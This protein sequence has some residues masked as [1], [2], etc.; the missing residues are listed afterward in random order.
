MHSF[1]EY[2]RPLRVA[3]LVAAAVVPWAPQSRA[4]TTPLACSTD[5]QIVQ[6]LTSNG[7][8]WEMC[9]DFTPYEGLVLRDIYFTAPGAERRKI[10]A[11]L[12]IGQI[13]VVYDKGSPRFEDVSDYGLAGADPSVSTLLSMSSSDCPGGSATISYM[14]KNRVCKRVDKNIEH[15]YRWYDT[16]TNTN[17]TKQ[18]SALVLYSMSKVG[19]YIYKPKWEFV[20]DGSIKP[21]M[22]ATG[23]LQEYTTDAR[24]GWLVNDTTEPYG[25][26]HIHNYYWR[27]HFGIKAASDAN[28]VEQIEFKDSGSDKREIVG[29]TAIPN[30]SARDVDPLQFRFWRVTNPAFKNGDGHVI[31][32]EIVPESSSIYRGPAAEPWTLHDLWVTENHL[33]ERTASN[34]KR[35][36]RPPLGA[37]SVCGDNVADYI[38][39]AEVITDPVVWYKVSFHHVP[40]DEDETNM[41]T[42]SV[43]FKLQPRDMTRL[44]PWEKKP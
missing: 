26:S 5:F 34:N 42:E 22:G 7:A 33:C 18:S 35:V 3:L 14:G 24:Y 4:Q 10:M 36:D 30:E 23:R 2:L 27:L 6:S 29:P 44:N 15:A 19:R 12:S 37:G 43:G 1:G 28:V 39:P 31:S 8:K 16:T 25:A 11:K 21:S 41:L 13:F 17:L 9:W 38:N 32:Y 40:R 20:D